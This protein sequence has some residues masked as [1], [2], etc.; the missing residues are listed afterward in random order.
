[1]VTLERFVV[2]W[3]YWCSSGIPLLQ[4]ETVCFWVWLGGTGLRVVV[5]LH[6]RLGYSWLSQREDWHGVGSKYFRMKRTMKGEK[7]LEEKKGGYRMKRW[8]KNE[9]QRQ[10]R[11]E[12]EGIET[13][14]SE[15]QDENTLRSNHNRP[16]KAKE[17]EHLITT[18]Y[19]TTLWSFS[20]SYHRCNYQ[21]IAWR[22]IIYSGMADKQPR[23]C[24]ATK[25]PSQVQYSEIIKS[26]PYPIT[27]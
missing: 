11:N 24:I 9:E 16:N 4:H 25:F 17:S 22:L 14:G 19:L 5:L 13:N 3:T 8:M 20:V 21:N 6:L 18:D 12:T 10:E 2:F 1:M 15:G 27:R 7:E 23:V 26:F